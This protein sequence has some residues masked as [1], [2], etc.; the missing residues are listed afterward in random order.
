MK[1]II[2]FS[3]IAALVSIN[4][5]PKNFSL[6]RGNWTGGVSGNFY[7]DSF[8]QNI[9]EVNGEVKSKIYENG[10]LMNFKSGY[11]AADNFLLGAL[12]YQAIDELEVEPDPNPNN[13][14]DKNRSNT[15][16]AGIWSRY[17][18]P[19]SAVNMSLFGELS[20]GYLAYEQQYQNLQS[21]IYSRSFTRAD[22]FAYIFGGGISYFL[23]DEISFELALN[24]QGSSTSGNVE[25]NNGV[26]DPVDI[27]F[28]N[29][30]ILLGIQIY[31]QN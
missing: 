11:F 19:I 13:N 22:G 20:L 25:Y 15:W 7:W 16:F 3:V 17:Y 8:D 10:S 9:K 5:Q 14:F 4:A 23:T 1:R 18:F 27:S 31:L 2:F 24:F 12:Y 28:F 30:K 26:S 6:M 21:N 29:T